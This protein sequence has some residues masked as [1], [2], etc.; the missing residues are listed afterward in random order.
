VAELPVKFPLPAYVAVIV[1]EPTASVVVDIL[2]APPT[3]AAD[4][5]ALLPDLKV[6]DPVG[7]ADVLE[8]T[9]AVNVTNWLAVDGFNEEDSDVLVAVLLTTCDNTGE[10]LVAWLASPLYITVMLCVPTVSAELARDAV[11]PARF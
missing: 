4:P 11:P 5:N 8:V 3:S 6:I 9:V 10:V 2:A 7:T 1:S